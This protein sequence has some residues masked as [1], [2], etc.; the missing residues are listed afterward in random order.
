MSETGDGMFRCCCEC[1]NKD[2]FLLEI[3]RKIYKTKIIETD[4]H[5]NEKQLISE[6]YYENDAF[7]DDERI[8]CPECDGDEVDT[9]N[10][11]KELYEFVYEHT[12]TDGSWSREI[13][14]E[15]L[16]SE[17]V[18]QELFIETMKR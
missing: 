1:G 16:R 10:S 14:P 17:E 11:L 13:L 5:L 8:L 3:V 7:D 4:T 2:K 18:Y 9:F 12:K 6:D 15:G